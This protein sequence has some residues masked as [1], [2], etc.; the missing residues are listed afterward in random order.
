M[1]PGTFECRAYEG[2]RT[3]AHTHKNSCAHTHTSKNQECTIWSS[4]IYKSD[5]TWST[6]MTWC[7]RSN[8][9]T[10]TYTYIHTWVYCCWSEVIQDHMHTL[11]HT[12]T[13]THNTYTHANTQKH[14]RKHAKTHKHIPCLLTWSRSNTRATHTRCN[15]YCTIHYNTLGQLTW[16]CSS[17]QTH[18]HTR[19]HTHTPGLLTWSRSNRQN[20]I[21]WEHAQQRASK[22]ACQTRVAGASEKI[23]TFI[24]LNI[25][26]CVCLCLYMYIHS[27]SA[28][29]RKSEVDIAP[30][31]QMKDTQSDRK[32]DKWQR[33]KISTLTKDIYTEQ[34]C[35]HWAKI[36]TLSKD[37]YTE[38]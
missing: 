1:L 13:H 35:L 5:Q 22:H 31:T 34:R 28:S 14:T 19:T 18:A 26:V 8:P 6:D 12:L 33:A 37:I 16:S 21:L 29:D 3:R 27:N 15:I 25:Y 24:Y 4:E 9:R 32:S 7:N 2:T 30:A 17:P 11:M 10:C 38:H 23:D 20:A 36:S